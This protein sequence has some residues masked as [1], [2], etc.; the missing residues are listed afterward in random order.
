MGIVFVAALLA[1]IAM[2]LIA[3]ITSTLRRTASVAYSRSRSSLPAAN[4]S[5]MRMFSPGT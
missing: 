4:R 1:W 5:S 3:K 2:E